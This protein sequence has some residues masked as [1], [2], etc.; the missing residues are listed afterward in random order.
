VDK[1]DTK[2][3]SLDEESAKL[4]TTQRNVANRSHPTG[5]RKYASSKH[6]QREKTIMK[7][8]V[9]ISIL[10]S[11]PLSYKH[12]ISRRKLVMLAIE[13][14]KNISFLYFM[15]FYLFFI[16][17]LQNIFMRFLEFQQLLTY[18]FYYFPFS[19]TQERAT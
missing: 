16:V 11:F 6:P 14:T 18:S 5:Q 12:F 15:T 4:K 17:D 10:F 9:I 19:L 8:C 1:L 13:I 7:T 2:Y 3:D